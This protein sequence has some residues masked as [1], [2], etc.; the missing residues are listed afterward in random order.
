MVSASFNLGPR[1]MV[2]NKPERFLHGPAVVVAPNGDWLVAY[3]DGLDD[4]G[5]DS[6]VNQMRSHDQGR[7]WTR[8]G[9]I[10]D[11]RDK[12]VGSRNPAFGL[13]AKGKITLVVQRAS[14]DEKLPHPESLLNSTYCLSLDNGKSYAY[15]GYV[16]PL[17]PRGHFGSSSH[18]LLRDGLLYMVAYSLDGIVLYVSEDDAS[19]WHR[20]SIVFQPSE[21]QEDPFYPTIVFRPDGSLLCQCHLDRAMENY[22]KVSEDNGSTWSESKPANIRL[23]HPVLAYLGDILIAVG[24]LMPVRLRTGFYMSADDGMTWAGPFDLAPDLP[25]GGGGYTAVIPLRDSMFIAFSYCIPPSRNEYLQANS[26]LGVTLN[27]VSV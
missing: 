25:N 17:R 21:F 22:Q 20:R 10:Y 15:M 4:P 8:D 14:P 5:R 26:I 2:D 19:S 6:F 13:T 12:R 18:I 7:T 3:Q 11:E 23:R 27:D 16:D 9:I 24:R 1:V